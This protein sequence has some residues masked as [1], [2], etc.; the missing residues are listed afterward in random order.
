MKSRK[1]LIK[2]GEIELMDNIL[3]LIELGVPIG[4]GIYIGF[5]CIKLLI[6]AVSECFIWFINR[7]IGDDEK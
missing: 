7:T 5:E 6:E 3:K 2:I 4:F 1:K